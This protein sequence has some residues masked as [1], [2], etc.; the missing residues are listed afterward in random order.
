MLGWPLKPQDP[1]TGLPMRHWRLPRPRLLPPSLWLLLAL[2]CWPLAAV[3]ET[4]AP[5]TRYTLSVI[6]IMPAGEIKRRWQPVVDAL[7]QATG[8]QLQ[9]RFY[10]GAERFETA[11]DNAEPDI[12]VAGPWQIWNS[13]HHYMPI[14]R[15]TTPL[16]GLIVVRNNSRFQQP[17]DLK[18]R[19][20]AVPEGRDIS[21][22]QLVLQ[23]LREQQVPVEVLPMRTHS[24][25]FRALYLGKVDAAAGNNITLDLL[26]PE[27]RNRFRVIYRSAPLPPPGLAV[28]QG[29][30]PE[31]VKLLREALLHLAETQPAVLANALGGK[32]TEADLERDYSPLSKLP[33]PEAVPHAP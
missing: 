6:P 17:A 28:R 32:V 9:L 8:L 10:D 5:A 31:H 1:E 7:T 13:R 22:R 11:L 24:N 18:G 3:A 14:V 29:M 19:R 16:V 15:D 30:P 2:L 4:P 25:G 20:L 27:I 26:E 12:M 23:A 33:P 21:A